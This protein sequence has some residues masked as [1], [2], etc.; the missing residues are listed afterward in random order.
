[1]P[2]GMPLK[3]HTGNVT[4]VTWS[5]NGQNIASGSDDYTIRIWDA[6]TGAPVGGPL[7]GHLGGITS[8]IYSPDGRYIVSGSEDRTIRVWDARQ[9]LSGGGECFIFL[10]R[11]IFI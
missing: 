5:P 3:G 8:V 2:V 9:I 7:R 1:M 10:R 11:W 6:S 4:S